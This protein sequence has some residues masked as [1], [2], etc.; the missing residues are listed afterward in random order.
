MRRVMNYF[1]HNIKLLRDRNHITQA[2]LAMRT[3]YHIN[4]IQL[5]EKGRVEPRLSGILA[6]AEVFHIRVDDLLLKNL[7][8]SR[9]KQ[10]GVIPHDKL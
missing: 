5:W 9:H 8:L 3:G 10:K 7:G 1:A 6:I 4:E 2:D